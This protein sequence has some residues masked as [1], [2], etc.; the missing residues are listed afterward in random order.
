MVCVWSQLISQNHVLLGAQDSEIWGLW[1]TLRDGSR[2]PP[3]RS[4]IPC[5][6]PNPS[7]LKP[8]LPRGCWVLQT[9]FS[10]HHFDVPFLGPLPV[11]LPKGQVCQTLRWRVQNWG[12]ESLLNKSLKG[13]PFSGDKGCVSHPGTQPLSPPPPS[14]PR[15]QPWH[16]FLPLDQGRRASHRQPS[17]TEPSGSG[18]A[19]ELLLS[20]LAHLPGRV[21]GLLEEM[22][23][24]QS[25][26]GPQFP[27]RSYWGLQWR[28]D[29]TRW[30]HRT[31]FVW[32]RHR[33][34]GGKRRLLP[35]SQPLLTCVLWGAWGK[36]GARARSLDRTERQKQK[37]K[38]NQYQNA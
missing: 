38:K 29:S 31:L 6:G 7:S 18:A 20:R 1:G 8:L 3:P 33:G 28:K 22:G 37:F 10:G 9:L 19:T 14:S 30:P 35:A 26:R 15:R 13:W 23:H 27:F 12:K 36:G 4:L 5:A 21:A 2:M 25:S 24:P 11:S 16:H 32:C 34:T 17:D